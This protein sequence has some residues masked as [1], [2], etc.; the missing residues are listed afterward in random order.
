MNVTEV[1]G[2]ICT[3]SNCESIRRERRIRS[4]CSKAPNVG[5]DGAKRSGLCHK[6]LSRHSLSRLCS[7]LL[8]LGNV[9]ATVLAVVNTLPSPCGF[10]RQGVHNL[11]KK[12]RI[13][14]VRAEKQEGIFL[15]WSQQKC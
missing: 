5:I 1:D 4:E 3:P 6:G 11:E 2:P 14:G 15:P 9:R 8:R 10:G 13:N 7:R 12:N